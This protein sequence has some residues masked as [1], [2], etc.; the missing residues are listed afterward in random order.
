[1]LGTRKTK[2]NS[3]IRS[4]PAAGW[5][6]KLSSST[7]PSLQGFVLIESLREEAATA[8]TSQFPELVRA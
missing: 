4:C 2:G 3:P 1:M 5:G 7:V 8:T 6:L